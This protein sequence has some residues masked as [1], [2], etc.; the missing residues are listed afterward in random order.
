MFGIIILALGLFLMSDM[1]IS[2]LK[3]QAVHDNLKYRAQSAQLAQ[4]SEELTTR[5]EVGL[6]LPV[7]E[8][9]LVAQY[10][11]YEGLLD[12]GF[13]DYEHT[14]STSGNIQGNRA[15]LMMV[16]NQTLSHQAIL[17]DGF[18]ACGG[19]F[20]DGD[21]WCPPA[22][23]ENDYIFWRFE[24][25]QHARQQTLIQRE[26]LDYIA[27]MIAEHYRGAEAYPSA[28]NGISDLASLTTPAAP[29]TAAACQSG[30]YSWDGIPL[31]CS[32][33]YNVWY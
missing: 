17:S 16:N 14:A 6:A 5:L 23:T 3:L 30:I 33:L 11:E 19:A 15:L 2:N 9:A 7:D 13:I 22:L 32:S 21:D 27:R 24:S 20:A 18:N 12:F 8:G 31:D 28:P 26:R 1:Q 10:P 25:V 29:A 4:L